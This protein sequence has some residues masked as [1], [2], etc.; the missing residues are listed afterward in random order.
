MP[1]RKPDWSSIAAWASGGVV[2]CG[3]AFTGK[4]L[5]KSGGKDMTSGNGGWTLGKSLSAQLL[6]G[7]LSARPA[8]G[9]KRRF[10][11]EATSW[12]L[13]HLISHL[14]IYSYAGALLR[15]GMD[16]S[17]IALDRTD[18]MPAAWQ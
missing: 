18:P 5:I 7:G 1:I 11:N 6:A 8:I 17:P 16:K 12:H 4:S 9:K 2:L 13:S 15:V 14:R 10:D 3:V